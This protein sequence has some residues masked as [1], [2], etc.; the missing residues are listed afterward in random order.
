MSS[1]KHLVNGYM[2][3]S[4]VW[5]HVQIFYTILIVVGYAIYN[6]ATHNNHLADNT[7]T[8]IGWC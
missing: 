2:I 6:R 1:C 7:F 5:I 3:Y 8:G 4:P